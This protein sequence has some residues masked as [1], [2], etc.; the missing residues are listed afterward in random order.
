MN[1][2]RIVRMPVTKFNEL[3]NSA[4]KITMLN[5]ELEDKVERLELEN[6][7]LSKE[8]P[9]DSYVEELKR[10]VSEQGMLIS[11]QIQQICDLT[12][13]LSK[14]TETIDNAFYVQVQPMSDKEQFE[15]YSRCEKEQLISMLIE[16]NK[17]LEIVKGMLNPYYIPDWGE[18]E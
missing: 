8:V 11:S 17:N 7:V 3:V 13:K 10:N 12:I 9:F 14:Y 15:M 6:K 18:Q 2:T 16:S 1:K 5:L 4:R